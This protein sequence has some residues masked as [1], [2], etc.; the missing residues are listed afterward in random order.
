VRRLLTAILYLSLLLW[1]AAEGL[2]VASGRGR[3]AVVML[4]VGVGTGLLGSVFLIL[5]WLLLWPSGQR[6]PL[7]EYARTIRSGQKFYPSRDV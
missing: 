1:L 7:S 3:A 4:A 6:P 2:A 5:P